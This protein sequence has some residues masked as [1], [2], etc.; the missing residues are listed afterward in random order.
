MDIRLLSLF[1]VEYASGEEMG[2]SETVTFFNDMC[3][4]APGSLTDERI[5][6]LEDNGN[7]VKAS[8]TVN[9]YTITALLYFDGEG[10]LVNFISDDRYALSSDGTM[11]RFTWS[12]PLSDYREVNGYQ[13]ATY[14]ETIYA[15]PEGDF[16][17]G[18]FMLTDVVYNVK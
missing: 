2:L 11:Q 7:K 8:F 12:T 15:Y 4:L 1:N 18:K 14:A 9:G 6:W 13:L 10:R 5:V 16:T 17:Y 3:C